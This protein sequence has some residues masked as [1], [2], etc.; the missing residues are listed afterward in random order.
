MPDKGSIT[1]WFEELERGNSSAAQPLWERYFPELVR[2]AREKLRGSARRAADEEDVALSVMDSFFE[3]A[4]CRRFPSVA[5][6]D[7][8]W[9][10]LLRMT[11]HKVV[12]H[13]RHAN[14]QRRG[15]GRVRSETDLHR[16]PP[17]EDDWTLAQVI[18]DT[19]NPE[20]AAM[21]AEECQMRLE[22][23]EDEQL[24]AIAV[25]KMQGYANPEIAAQLDCSVRT[26]ERRLQLIRKKWEQ[27]RPS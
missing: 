19:P 20:F 16:S 17:A 10:L 22:R 2:L 6:R 1:Q 5:D 23:L 9:R 7:D 3:A 13:R 12:D 4:Q 26:V 25:A 18:G 14:R 27:E 21:M 24:R 15:G 8:L 11:A